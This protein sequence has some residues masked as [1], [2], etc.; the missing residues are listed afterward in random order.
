MRQRAE[1]ILRGCGVRCGEAADQRETGYNRL[2]GAIF[3]K[4]I[5]GA[6]ELMHR[7]FHRGEFR[8]A[9]GVAEIRIE[10][11]FDVGEIRFHLAC[12]LADEQLILRALRDFL[13]RRILGRGA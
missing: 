8:K 4:N 11:F 1:F 3:A 9:R 6:D 12:D 2:L 7:P 5:E 13:H 10:R